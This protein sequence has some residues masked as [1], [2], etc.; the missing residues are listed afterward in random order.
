MLT[1]TSSDTGTHHA[2]AQTSARDIRIR[3]SQNLVIERM[4]ADPDAARSTIISTGSV[5]EGLACTVQQG[6]FSAIMDLGHAM[7]GDAAGPSPGFFARAGIVGCVAIATKMA[8]ARAGISIR[9]IMVEVETDFDDLAIFGLGGSS[10]APTETRVTIS[11]D[12]DEDEAEIS[13]LVARVLEIDPWFL[14]LR[15]A[16]NVKT[17]VQPRVKGSNG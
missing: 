7:G 13:G 14:A 9:Q 15:D 11:I 5:R 10:A 16:Q 4:K 17:S 1:N 3:D 6:K 12:S 2:P 8:A